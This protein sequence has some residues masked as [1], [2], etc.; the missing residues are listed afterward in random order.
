MAPNTIYAQHRRGS[1]RRAI[2]GRRLST[3]HDDRQ[4]RAIK[5]RRAR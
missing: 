1:T 4:E 5:S 2:T 3:V